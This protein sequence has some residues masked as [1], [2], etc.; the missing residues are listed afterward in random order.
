MLNRS[1]L[2]RIS[3]VT[4]VFNR[5]EFLEDTIVSVIS[6]GY[7]DL[8]YIIIDGGS[9]DGSLEIIKKYEKAISVVIS[10]PDKGMYAAIQKGFDRS[11]GEIMAWLNSD[12][13]YKPGSLFMTAS[14]FNDTGVEWISGMSSLFNKDGYCVK[15][16]N[17][18]KW[19]K[20]LF[21]FNDFSWIQQESIFWKRSLWERSGGYVST[22]LKY[23]GD[24]ELWC[25]FFDH[26]ELYSIY[27]S[28]AGF[29]L[30]GS[31]ITAEFKS[32]YETEATNIA[33]KLIHVKSAD[34]RKYYRLS[35]FKWLQKAARFSIIFI[36][37]EPF[38]AKLVEKLHTFPGV[39]RYNF[40]EQKWEIASKKRR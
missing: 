31:Q 36:F 16:N 24:F 13:K 11:T 38:L 15:T 39:I 20:S 14:I 29:R 12:D 40:T 9:T 2:P 34:K 19:S 37:L 17:L 27:T 23:A 18:T 28:L 10:E 1:E 21:W 30:H 3:I 22:D 35:I 33:G 32:E 4:P 6:Q 5:V 25:R 26:A 8:E 7:P